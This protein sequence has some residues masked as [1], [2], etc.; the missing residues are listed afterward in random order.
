MNKKGLLLAMAMMAMGS[1]GMMG[2]PPEQ[3]EQR[4]SPNEKR[5]CFKDGCSN[6]RCGRTE[7]Y[8]A[9]HKKPTKF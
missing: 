1:N 7:L 6:H 5:K 4:L 9:E 3:E 8:C 2:Y